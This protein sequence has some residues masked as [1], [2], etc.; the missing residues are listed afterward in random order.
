MLDIWS[1][2][3]KILSMFR[4][5]ILCIMPL[6][7]ILSCEQT[8]NNSIRN[9]ALKHFIERNDSINRD[10]NNSFSFGLDSNDYSHKTLKA[11]HEND[12]NFLKKI[13]TIWMD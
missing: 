5:G 12:T 6:I 4:K 10:S 7:L 8:D 2:K 9:K 1:G 11:Y 3:I 13:I